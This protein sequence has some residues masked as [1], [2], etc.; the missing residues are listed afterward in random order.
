[1][2]KRWLEAAKITRPVGLRGE[3]R[4]Q[5]YCDNYD[6][7][8]DFDMYLGKEHKLVKVA[9]VA[10]LKNDMC[11]LRIEGVNTVE[12]A[13]LLTGKM[14][15]L[16]REDAELPEDTWFIADLIGL[17]VYDADSG[18]LYGKID[19]ILQNG[20]TDVYSIKTEEGKQ[21]LFPG[22]PEV[23]I[24]VDVDGEKIFIR[25]LKGLFDEE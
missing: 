4:A 22:I 1:M 6:L 14:L 25:P 5:L 18:R 23:L 21:L 11:K 3:M 16:D 12:E 13:Q 8:T 15:Y 19:E 9:A 20:P 10:P 2:K 7:L 17:P 24:D